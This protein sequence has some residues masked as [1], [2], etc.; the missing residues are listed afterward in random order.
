[1]HLRNATQEVRMNVPTPLVAFIWS[2][3]TSAAA[4]DAMFS[5]RSKARH[6]T[7]Q[8]SAFIASRGPQVDRVRNARR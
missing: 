3:D 1:M 5:R 6:R 8:F 2:D 7:P 4:V